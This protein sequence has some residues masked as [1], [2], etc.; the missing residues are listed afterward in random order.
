M[1]TFFPLRLLSFSFP[2]FVLSNSKSGAFC[3]TSR[4]KTAEMVVRKN[5]TDS[6]EDSVTLLTD[7]IG[8]LLIY[9]P[10]SLKNG[11]MPESQT[12]VN[13]YLFIL[14]VEFL[15]YSI[16]NLQQVGFS[17]F[18]GDRI[19]QLAIDPVKY[20]YAPLLRKAQSAFPLS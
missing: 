7:R 9:S 11:Y 2:P 6:N 19:A 12:H 20:A 5:K 1:R 4:A 10:I 16:G 14:G 3:P 8:S 17:Q 18:A 15:V 13:P